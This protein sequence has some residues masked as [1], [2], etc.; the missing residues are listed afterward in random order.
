MAT[1]DRRRGRPATASRAITVSNRP[2]TIALGARQ[3]AGKVVGINVTGGG[4]AS[5]G[6][7]SR[8]DLRTGGARGLNE[9]EAAEAGFDIATRRSSRRR[10]RA[11]TRVPRRSP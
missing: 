6:W 11:T 5:A 4:R 7:D 10:A 8:Y 1:S 2:V 9:R 3:Q